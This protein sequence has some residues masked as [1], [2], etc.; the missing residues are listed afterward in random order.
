MTRGVRVRASSV[1]IVHAVDHGIGP[2]LSIMYAYRYAPR[3][4]C[5]RQWS[6]WSLHDLPGRE[7]LL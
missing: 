7:S 6:G 1:V 4:I 3:L 5:K 2:E